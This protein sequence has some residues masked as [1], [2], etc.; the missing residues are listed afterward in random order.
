M[1]DKQ[2]LKDILKNVIL[3][4]YT[5]CFFDLYQGNIA[6]FLTVVGKQHFEFWG[7]IIFS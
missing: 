4:S 5:V 6:F 2:K 1:T 3:M 7:W